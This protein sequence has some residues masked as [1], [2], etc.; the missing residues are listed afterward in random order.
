MGIPRPAELSSLWSFPPLSSIL[1]ANRFS[2]ILFL[3]LSNTRDSSNKPFELRFPRSPHNDFDLPLVLCDH[4]R[5]EDAAPVDAR[6]NHRA[7]SN[8]AARI[9]HGVAADFRAVADERAKFAQAGVESGSA[10]DIHGDWAR[11]GF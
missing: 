8:D 11:Q 1:A 5:G 10:L 6:I 3:R 2:G 9:Q 7:P 4:V